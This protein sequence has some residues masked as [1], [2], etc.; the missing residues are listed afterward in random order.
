MTA[1][2]RLAYSVAILAVTFFLAASICTF[3]S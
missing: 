1:Q 2:V 3:F